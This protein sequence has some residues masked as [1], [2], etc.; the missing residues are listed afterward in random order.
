MALARLYLRLPVSLLDMIL[1]VIYMHQI[2]FPLLKSQN[3]VNYI[4]KEIRKER[5]VSWAKCRD[6]MGC[7][8]MR[9][10]YM[11]IR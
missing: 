2:V 8:N 9:I 7:M 6:K 1:D 10:T 5:S 11:R 3:D 4:S